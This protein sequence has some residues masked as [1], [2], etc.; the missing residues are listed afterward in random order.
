VCVF[1]KKIMIVC[2]FSICSTLDPA[3]DHTHV[4]M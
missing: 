1:D 4:L 3:N 2:S